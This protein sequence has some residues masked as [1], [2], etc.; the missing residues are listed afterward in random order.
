MA[1]GS[2]RFIACATFIG[3]LL[4]SAAQAEQKTF[5]ELSQP[6]SITTH[7][8]F[9]AKV[10]PD[11]VHVIFSIR[12][13]DK[14]LSDAFKANSASAKSLIA[15]SDELKIDKV[16]VQ[17]GDIQV[18]AEY[19]TNNV[20]HQL[21]RFT[22]VGYTVTRNVSFVLKDVNKLA[23]L[24]D[25]GLKH[26]ANGIESAFYE[27]SDE[28]THRAAAR[29]AALKAARDKANQ[30]AEAVGGKVGKPITIS[31]GYVQSSPYAPSLSGATNGTIG[32]QGSDATWVTGVNGG[33]E[34]GV[35]EIDSDVTATFEL[36]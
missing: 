17:T 10:R 32:P 24:L 8:H 5:V 11:R 34:L 25:A 22:P 21:N 18:R 27:C 33:I 35:L 26:G 13:F 1:L 7:G 4:P 12:T 19:A 23:T 20:T 15:L 9:Q 16:D 30:L 31:E 28:A 3:V 6:H 29:L 36:E 14:A 2:K